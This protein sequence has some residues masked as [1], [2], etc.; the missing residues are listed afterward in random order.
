MEPTFEEQFQHCEQQLIL[1][2][3][4]VSTFP[5]PCALPGYWTWQQFLPW[6]QQR[7]ICPSPGDWP[8]G[9]GAMSARQLLRDQYLRTL[10]AQQLQMVSAQQQAAGRANS[11]C[12][13]SR[14]YYTL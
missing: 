10:S 5:M 7:N 6:P 4:P 11:K 13:A 8:Q 2:E 12:F 14:S 3:I 9:V 1:I